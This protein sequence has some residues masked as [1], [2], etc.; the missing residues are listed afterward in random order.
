[1]TSPSQPSATETDRHAQ[2]A[3]RVDRP[4]VG[5]T[6]IPVGDEMPADV[7]HQEQV[8]AVGGHDD[9]HHEGDAEGHPEVLRGVDDFADVDGF[10]GVA[11]SLR[12]LGTGAEP[13]TRS[14]RGRP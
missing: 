14:D 9:D 2:Q 8:I 12:A 7:P 13:N 10:L 4:E 6:D 5:A 3:R 1:M 11:H